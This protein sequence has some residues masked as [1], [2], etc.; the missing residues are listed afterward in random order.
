MPE[1]IYELDIL[2]F[3]ARLLRAEIDLQAM[4]AENK[5]RELLGQSMAYT[6]DDF[7]NLISVHG[8]DAYNVPCYRG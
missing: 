5:Q 6:G 2:E 3:K 8:I 4:I 7:I 1:I